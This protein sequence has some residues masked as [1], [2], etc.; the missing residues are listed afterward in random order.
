MLPNEFRTLNRKEQKGREQKEKG[1]DREE[2]ARREQESTC[3]GNSK[4]GIRSF[5]VFCF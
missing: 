1:D 5:F 2:R 3:R 4:A